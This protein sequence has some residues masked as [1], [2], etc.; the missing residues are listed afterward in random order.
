MYISSTLVSLFLASS[1]VEA[2]SHARR[3]DDHS[4]LATALK[5]SDYGPGFSTTLPSLKPTST[6][7]SQSPSTSPSTP[8]PTPTPDVPGGHSIDFSTYN[9]TS[10]GTVESFLNKHGYMV[11]KYL[12]END[13]V[14]GSI[15]RE[16][17]KENV[18]IKNG[19]LRLKV[20]G[21]PTTKGSKNTIISSEI[22]S[23]DSFNYGTLETWAKATPVEGVCQGIFFYDS[24]NAEVDIE[25]LSSYYNKGYRQY[26]DPG[27]QYTNQALVEGGKSTSIGQPYGFDPTADFHNYTIRWTPTASEFYIDGEHRNSFDEN[28]PVNIPS[29]IIYNNW[30]N[31]DKKWSAGPPNADAYFEIKSFKYTP[32]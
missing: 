18:D 32:L 26:L 30:A 2:R 22:E 1:L 19:I 14:E 10:D 27:V 5:P 23:K 25:L 3:C 31:G 20:N 11:S 6:K 9:P 24:D 4:S 16:F 29:K 13:G 28:V 7:S 17:V 8:T 12:I 15:P 21:Q